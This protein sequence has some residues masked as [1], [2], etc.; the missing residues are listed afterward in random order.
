M[1]TLTI[2]VSMFD[3]HSLVAAHAVLINI[4]AQQVDSYPGALCCAHGVGLQ[5]AAARL[6]KGR[7]VL[8]SR[9][10][11]FSQL[12]LTSAQCPTTVQSKSVWRRICR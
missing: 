5:L 12:Q 10:R 7:P 3:L 6:S 11:C 4:G 2:C 8:T 1:R 9:R